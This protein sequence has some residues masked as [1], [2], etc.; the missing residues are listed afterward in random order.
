MRPLPDCD[1]AFS[2]FDLVAVAAGIA[3]CRSLRY[4]PQSARRVLGNLLAYLAAD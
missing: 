4:Q 2:E 1:V 3:N